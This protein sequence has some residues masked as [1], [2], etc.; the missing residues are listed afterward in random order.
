MEYDSLGKNLHATMVSISWVGLCLAILLIVGAEAKS[1][2][3]EP[4]DVSGDYGSVGSS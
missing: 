3:P 1:T 2:K 4:L